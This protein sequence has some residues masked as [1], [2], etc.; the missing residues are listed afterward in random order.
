MRRGGVAGPAGPAKAGPLFSGSLVSFSDCR[1]SLRTR[2]LCQVSCASL[3]L[4]CVY[5]YL[6]YNRSP[7]LPADQESGA[8]RPA[9]FATHALDFISSFHCRTLPVVETPPPPPPPPCTCTS[10]LICSGLTTLEMPAPPL[11]ASTHAWV[12]AAQAS[13]EWAVGWRTCF[14]GSTISGFVPSVQLCVFPR[15]Y[16]KLHEGYK[17]HTPAEAPW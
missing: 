4:P 7:F 16:I 9:C 5:A 10:D 14:I 1:D 6:V 17:P 3:P 12:L 2:R 8:A 11:R 15:E 13:K